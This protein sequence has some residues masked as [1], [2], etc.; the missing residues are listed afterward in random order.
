MRWMR[1]K[2]NDTTYM[3]YVTNDHVQPVGASNLLEITAGKGLK[4][5]GDPVPLET[6]HPLAPLR[7]GKLIA[8]GNNYWDH[9]RE[10]KLE[11]PSKPILFAKFSTSVIGSGEAIRWPTGL[12]EQVDFEA[13]LAV[14][15]GKRARGLREANALQA[16]FGYTAA[17]DVSARDLQ[18]SDGQ[19]LR[20]KALDTFCPLGPVVVTRDEVSDP[21]NLPVRCR[22]NGVTYQD[23]STR[24]MIFSVRALLAF[25]S[26]AF[27]LEPGDIVLTGTPHGVGVFRNPQVFLKPGDE[28][29]VEVSDFGALINP[30]GPYLEV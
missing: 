12:T 24:E 9:C 8:V 17:N 7:P 10:Q 26:Q 4:S 16:V 15:I 28:V 3:G 13:E 29:E 22:V 11:P 20:G 5:I 1:F 25:V 2:H 18:F 27:T 6:I 19:W 21:Q 14:V 23:S 30:V